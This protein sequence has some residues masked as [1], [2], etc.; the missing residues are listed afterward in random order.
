[1]LDSKNNV[2]VD[3]VIYYIVFSFKPN[4]I[5]FSD[6]GLIV[7]SILY[8]LCVAIQHPITMLWLWCIIV[9]GELSLHCHFINEGGLFLMFEALNALFD[10]LFDQDVDEY[11]RI[12]DAVG[13]MDEM[14]GDEWE[15]IYDSASDLGKE[16]MDEAVSGFADDAIGDSTWR[17]GTDFED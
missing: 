5:L 1:M 15:Q 12:Q 10:E 7:K 13:R 6:Y 4:I 16:V 17:W 2:T 3:S 14:S 8:C 9:I 11:Q